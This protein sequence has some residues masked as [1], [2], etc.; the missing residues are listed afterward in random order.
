L[1]ADNLSYLV[2]LGYSTPNSYGAP[3]LWLFTYAFAFQI[4][5]DF[6]GY[7]DIGRGSAMLFGYHIPI[8]FNLPFIAKNMSDFWHRWHISLSTWLR[9]YL[10]IPMGGSRQGEFKT[11]RNLFITF[12]I[13][14]LWHG[15]SWS[16]VIWGVFHGLC[17]VGHRTFNNLSRKIK[18]L[19]NFWE[20]PVWRYFSIFLTF[21]AVCIGDV[22]FR[23]QDSKMAFNVVRKMLTLH[24][25]FST[26]EAGRFFVLKPDMPVA[27]PVIMAVVAGLI[28]LNLP[29]S[30][31]NQKGIFRNCPPVLKAAF[32]AVV[33]IGMVTLMPD[34]SAPFVYF[35][36]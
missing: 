13:G 33:V 29:L 32:C 24:P 21:Q 22:F 34:S 19:D 17:L 25:I 7:T 14:G 8:N 11:C 30:A 3:E 35:Q 1:L 9:D 36:F 18:A 2:Q 28:V 31:A 10:F 27:V 26:E 5:F 20:T 6:S 12:A 16:F 4:Y 15:A 23:I